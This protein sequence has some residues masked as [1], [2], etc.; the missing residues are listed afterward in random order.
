MTN[1]N[2]LEKP[3]MIRRGRRCAN[4]FGHINASRTKAGKPLAIHARV[5]IPRRTNNARHSSRDQRI[6]ARRR[7]PM[8]GA[9]FQRDISCCALGRRARRGQRHCFGM[10]AATILCP[11]AA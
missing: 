11:A 2:T 6:T 10:R 7:M 1:L 3:L 9:R 4:P 5:W 8:V